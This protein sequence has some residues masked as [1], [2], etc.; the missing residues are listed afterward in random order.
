MPAIARKI[1]PATGDRPVDRARR[2]FAR[3]LTPAPAVVQ[4]ALRTPL[5]REIRKAFVAPPGAARDRTYGVQRVDNAAPNAAAVWRLAV[6]RALSRWIRSGFLRDVEVESTVT[7][8][9]TGGAALSYTVTFKGRDGRR[10][11]FSSPRV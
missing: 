3:A 5:G 10:Q 9:R 2:S 8:L 1:D 6:L 7:S 4:N 11:S